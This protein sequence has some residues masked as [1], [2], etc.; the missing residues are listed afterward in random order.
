MAQSTTSGTSSRR[1][2]KDHDVTAAN[3][4]SPNYG[5]SEWET[6]EVQLKIF[7]S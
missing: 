6:K 7:F 2:M 4:R 5:D 3:V 1:H